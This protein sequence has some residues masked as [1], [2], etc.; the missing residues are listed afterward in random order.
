ML[1]I[2]KWCKTHRNIIYGN[3]KDE[4]N[5][6]IHTECIWETLKFGEREKSCQGFKK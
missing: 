3:Q 1:V 6:Y 2:A 4:L 5:Q